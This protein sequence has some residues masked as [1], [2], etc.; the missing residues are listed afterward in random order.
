MHGRLSFKE[1][2]VHSTQTVPE[3]SHPGLGSPD[4]E[5]YSKVKQRFAASFH[6]GLVI[7]WICRSQPTVI[8][9]PIWFSLR[10][11]LNASS[12]LN[13]IA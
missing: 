1:G 12:C 5:G 11:L 6:P 3:V 7:G 8:I 10:T 9:Y 4:P 2:P 13:G